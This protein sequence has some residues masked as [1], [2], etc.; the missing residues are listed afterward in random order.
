MRKVGTVV[1]G[2]LYPVTFVFWTK[3]LRAFEVLY[4]R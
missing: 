2:C 1:F 3:G 4:V